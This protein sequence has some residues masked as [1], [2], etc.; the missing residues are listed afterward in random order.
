MV[1]IFSCGRTGTNL[2]LEIMTGSSTLSPSPYPEDKQIFKRDIVYPYNYLTKNDS[3]YCDDFG[4]LSDFMK[5]NFHCKI[6]WTV[7]HPYDVAIS[8]IYRGWGHADDAN[9]K[10]CVKDMFWAAYLFKEAIGCFP[11]RV[12]PTKMEDIIKNAKVEIG[13]ICF[14]LNIK[15]EEAMLY[16]NLRMR[17]ELYKQEYSKGIHK[18]QIDKYKEWKTIYDGFFVNKIDFDMRELFEKI[19]PLVKTYGYGDDVYV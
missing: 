4:M 2:V 8:K 10:G 5:K 7:R 15:F 3:I 19:K 9:L 12:R 17:H 11:D 14:F 6:L 13:S 18:D 1:L 16:P